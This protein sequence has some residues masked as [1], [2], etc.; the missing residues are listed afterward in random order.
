MS[1]DNGQQKR[2]K[3]GSMFIECFG[4]VME[5]SRGCSTHNF[6]DI[7]QQTRCKMAQLL[8]LPRRSS[9]RIVLQ[10]CNTMPYD[11]EFS[12]DQQIGIKDMKV[13]TEKNLAI[14]EQTVSQCV[15]VRV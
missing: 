13:K 4:M 3:Y 9:D 12:I 8:N 11:I 10:D 7:L 2:H 6:N 5:E 14:I 15:L 1:I